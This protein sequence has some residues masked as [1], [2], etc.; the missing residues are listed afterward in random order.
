M[1]IQLIQQ[2]DEPIIR[3]VAGRGRVFSF[4]FQIFF[5]ATTRQSHMVVV[6]R[7]LRLAP[8]LHGVVI[9]ATFA[10]PTLAVCSCD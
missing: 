3:V 6:I 8:S 9:H 1:F 2:Q 4:V 7:D 10:P 5:C